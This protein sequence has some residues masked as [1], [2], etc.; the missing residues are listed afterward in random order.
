[1]RATLDRFAPS[2]VLTSEGPCEIDQDA[3][4]VATFHIYG[5]TLCPIVISR[6]LIKPN[7]IPE[8][9]ALARVV[10]CL[11]MQGAPVVVNCELLE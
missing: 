5:V 10:S 7:Q 3:P 6:C 11:V 1:M 8:T 9:I 2:R 4:P